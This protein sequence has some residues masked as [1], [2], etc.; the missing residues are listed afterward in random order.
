MLIKAYDARS[1]LASP[2]FNHHYAHHGNFLRESEI[3]EM[4][5]FR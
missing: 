5:C 1:L 4:L 2:F 3:V